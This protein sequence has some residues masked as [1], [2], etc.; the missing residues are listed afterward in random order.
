MA[1]TD[2]LPGLLVALLEVLLKSATGTK[3]RLVAAES[4]RALAVDS[5]V[6]PL[7]LTSDQLLAS[8]EYCQ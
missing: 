5:A 3:R 4:T 6:P 1:I 7:G 8:T 2:R